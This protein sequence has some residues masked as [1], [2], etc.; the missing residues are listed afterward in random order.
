MNGSM[1]FGMLAEYSTP[2]DLMHAARGT[3]GQRD[4]R[5]RRVGAG[6]TLDGTRQRG[7][8]MDRTF[9]RALETPWPSASDVRPPRLNGPPTP[10]VPATTK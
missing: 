10:S 4:L 9:T 6:R 3:A 5:R 8:F 1:K 2:A 7:G